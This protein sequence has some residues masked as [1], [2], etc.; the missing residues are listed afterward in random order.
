MKKLLMT[1]LIVALPVSV[2]ASDCEYNDQQ[3]GAN[4]TVKEI[5][6]SRQDKHYEM[7]IWRDSRRVAH[8]YQ[9]SKITNEW[10]QVSNGELRLVRFF[11]ED[12]RAIEYQPSEVRY[13]DA[14]SHWQRMNQL[15]T[16]AMLEEMTLI[17][18]NGKG[19]DVAQT[20]QLNN[21]VDQVE[22]VWLPAMKVVKLLR[23]NSQGV[24]REWQLQS[25]VTD[26]NTVIAAFE[27][28][29]NYQST[30]YTDI[31]DHESDPFFLKMMNLGHI[32]HGASGFY[33]EH[34]HQLD[35][36]HQH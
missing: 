33:D 6:E 36:H 34:G 7:T 13:G 19:C 15:V 21:G 17:S 2:Q 31:G 30:D 24:T 26:P 1:G 10:E 20:Y 23:E 11:D 12:Q 25:L 18:S 35:G 16:D 4:Y 29:G 9:T 22:L 32:D 28:R 3:L 27:T 5:S 14:T 8:E